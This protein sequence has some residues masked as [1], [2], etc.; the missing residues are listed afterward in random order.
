MKKLFLIFLIL[1]VTCS[2]DKGE[3]KIFILPENYVGHV[4]ILYN[5][6]DGLEKKYEGNKRVYEIPT[7]GVLKTKFVADYGWTEFPEFYYGKIQDDRKIPLIVEAEDF[8][9]DKINATML[10]AGKSYKDI[11]GIEAIE[12]STFFVGTKSQIKEAS[13]ALEKLHVADLVEN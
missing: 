8:S 2:C 5:Q 10:S 9:E 7:S 12:Y 13:K 6:S 1:L 11:D 4:I 3:D